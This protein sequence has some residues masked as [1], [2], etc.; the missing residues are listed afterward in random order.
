MKR[1]NVFGLMGLVVGLAACGGGGGAAAG[2]AA[3][4]KSTLPE[5][6]R[7]GSK[8]TG[9]ADISKEAAQSYKAAL[10]E[11]LK[12]DHASDWA[13]AVCEDRSRCNGG[14]HCPAGRKDGRLEHTDWT[15]GT[16]RHMLDGLGV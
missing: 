10:A 9:G 4:G 15:F 12:H 7:S 2:G 16:G 6:Q 13:P 8:S 1:F 11:F 5:G 3:S 14:G